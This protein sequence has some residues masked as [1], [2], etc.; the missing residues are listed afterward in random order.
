LIFAHKLWLFGVSFHTWTFVVLLA[1]IGIDFICKRRQGMPTHFALVHATALMTFT[2]HFYEIAHSGA[3]KYFT[4]FQSLSTWNLNFPTAI[5][6]AGVLIYLEL[7]KIGWGTAISCL[8]PAIPLHYMGITGFFISGFPKT[9]M[10]ALSKVVVS[11]STL[12]VFGPK[13]NVKC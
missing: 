3:E 8:L 13:G 6:A 4:G 10:W 12:I 1:T 2:T 11:I 9:W 7:P 5:I